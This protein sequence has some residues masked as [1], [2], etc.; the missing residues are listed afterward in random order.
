MSE[1]AVLNGYALG[2]S[3]MCSPNV[4]LFPFTYMSFK[5]IE[6]YKVYL[7]IAIFYEFPPFVRHKC[8]IRTTNNHSQ[9][10]RQRTT[11]QDYYLSCASQGEC[12]F[13]IST[14]MPHNRANSI[15]LLMVVVL[16]CFNEYC[17]RLVTV[18]PLVQFQLYCR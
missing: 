4:L 6:L 10:R 16:M 11:E 9:I 8:S 14:A 13:E 7:L 2:K 17:I 5:I 18:G 15:D 3:N 1:T 12:F